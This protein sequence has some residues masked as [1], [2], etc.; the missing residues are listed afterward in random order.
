M[1]WG[2]YYEHQAY[3]QQR[4]DEAQHEHLARAAR[5]AQKQSRLAGYLERLIA[6]RHEKISSD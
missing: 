4:T 2:S 3:L 1:K 5:D 6:Y